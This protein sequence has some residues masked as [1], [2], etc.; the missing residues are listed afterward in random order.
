MGS[1]V[2]PPA[3]PASVQEVLRR[4]NR[5]LVVG[6]APEF[7]FLLTVGNGNMVFQHGPGK[8]A[9]LIFT[10]P[11]AAADYLRATGSQ[12]KIGTMKLDA[13]PHLAKGWMAAGCENFI[14]NRCPRCNIFLLTKTEILLNR[15]N[16]I[17]IW[18]LNRATQ[19]LR[20][21]RMAQKAFANLG[22]PAGQP[23]GNSVYDPRRFATARME[24]ENIRDHVT[25]SVPYVHQMIA[26]IAT[27]QSDDAA[28]AAAAER[29]REFG[30]Q[31]DGKTEYSPEN[32][33]TAMVGLMLNFMPDH[34]KLAQPGKLPPFA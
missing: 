19:W 22:K 32:L 2:L 9:M 20:A 11:H 30:A 12:A 33:A 16:F 6:A 14:I 1:C 31:F 28:K 4:F 8:K 24:L 7:L 10:T 18:A 21:E 29:L 13:L 25:C 5:I 23:G 26:M 15:E 17:K 34:P 27:A 3:D